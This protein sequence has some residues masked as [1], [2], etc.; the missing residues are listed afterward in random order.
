[1]ID[2][3]LAQTTD[4]LSGPRTLLT[5]DVFGRLL[6]QREYNTTNLY[7]N[8]LKNGVYYTYDEGDGRLTT[9][10][11]KTGLGAHT[12]SVTYGNAAS[13]QIPSN[14]YA[15]HWNGTKL[16]EYGYD[17][18]GRVSQVKT[19]TSGGQAITTD[20]TYEALG[21]GKT[22]GRVVGYDTNTYHMAYAYDANGNV[23]TYDDGIYVTTYT[24]DALNRLT[25]EN[26]QK[27][28]KTYVYTYANG[29]LTSR[30]TYTYTT[31][32]LGAVQS[33]ESY[34]YGKTAFHDRVTVYSINTSAVDK[35]VSEFY[36]NWR[37]W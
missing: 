18:L 32:T 3:R 20:Y 35:K 14:V 34:T 22:S 2:G 37:P 8:T 10:G 29:N 28:G 21:G 7:A 23:T 11:T 30:K 27:A 1:M 36:N 13:G 19:Y 25:R 4:T 12:L 15:E 26:N 16:R 31:G 17:K 9:V 33:T 6:S 5:Y 24:Y